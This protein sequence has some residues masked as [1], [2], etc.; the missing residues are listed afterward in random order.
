M[1]LVHLRRAA[2]AGGA[3]AA[4]C[5]WA[6]PDRSGLAVRL[7]SAQGTLAA[8]A[9]LTL[10]M[11]LPTSRARPKTPRRLRTSKAGGRR[12]SYGS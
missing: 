9:E 5:L 6:M 7:I 12:V 8:T 4:T 11:D 3:W 2:V 10:R 1:L